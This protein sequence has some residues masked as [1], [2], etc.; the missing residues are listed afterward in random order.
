MLA[1]SAKSASAVHLLMPGAKADTAAATS[2]GINITAYEGDLM[3]TQYVGVVTAGQVA[4]KIQVCDDAS[5]T[6]PVDVTGAT[7]TAVTTS[8]DNPNIQKITLDANS[9]AK[10]FIRYLGTVTTGPVDMAVTLHSRP[11]YL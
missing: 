8:N 1:N 6:N 4:G 9:L 3:I 7:F 2:G 11:K 10:P 5:G